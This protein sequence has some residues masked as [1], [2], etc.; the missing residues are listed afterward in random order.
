[1]LNKPQ[2]RPRA[3]VAG[4][5]QANVS[6]RKPP[7]N[8]GDWDDFDIPTWDDSAPGVPT[9]DHPAPEPASRNPTNRGTYPDPLYDDYDSHGYPSQTPTRTPSS[10]QQP[11]RLSSRVPA[12][13]TRPSQQD[14]YRDPYSEYDEP[15]G[16]DPRYPSAPAYDEPVYEEPAYGAPAQRGGAAS[17]YDL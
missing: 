2:P 4:I 7:S 11:P 8:P 12:R 16:S 14:P 10:G 9:R 6:S 1:M 15:Y 17:Q 3:V 5:R 13:T